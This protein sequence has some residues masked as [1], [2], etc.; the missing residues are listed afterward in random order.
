MLVRPWL[1]LAVMLA[2]PCAIGWPELAA[3]APAHGGSA[4]MASVPTLMLW[5][6]EQ[7][8]DLRGIDPER[9]GV[10]YLARTLT[11]TGDRVAVRPRLQPL[12]V[13]P[14][15]RLVAVARIECDRLA[16][17]ALDPAQ[18]RRGVAL[19]RRRG[20]LGVQVD[21]DAARSQRGFYREL[22]RELR[23]ALPDSTALSM[24]ALGSWCVGDRWLDGLPVDE[25]VPML[26]RMG[27]D[28][29]RVREAFAASGHACANCGGSVGIATDEP[30]PAIAGARRL[31]VFHAGSWT[32]SA[33]RWALAHA[34]EP[35]LSARGETPR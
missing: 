8:Q 34:P 15:T 12:L 10:A 26:F 27:A 17:P 14:G 29:H 13:P 20:V 31:Y 7:P 23:Q 32:P 5:A 1:S 24:T 18:R 4:R 25:V 9:A 11:L 28:A 21:F 19:A 30:L 3:G 16:P 33:L 22:L 2:A 6:W 35:A